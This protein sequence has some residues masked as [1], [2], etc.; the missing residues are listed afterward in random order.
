MQKVGL[1]FETFCIV[2]SPKQFISHSHITLSKI[3]CK[4]G[5]IRRPIFSK[6]GDVRAPSEPP[7]LRQWQQQR[8]HGRLFFRIIIDALNTVGYVGF[9]SASA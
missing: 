3:V 6:S 5:R 9:Y 7:W 8:Q 1:E 4:F 2:E